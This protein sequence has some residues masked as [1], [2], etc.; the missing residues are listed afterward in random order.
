MEDII[1]ILSIQTNSD[2]KFID[3]VRIS[4]PNSDN[5]QAPI[6]LFDDAKRKQFLDKINQNNDTMVTRKEFC[7]GISD[8]VKTTN[9]EKTTLKEK[10]EQLPKPIQNN[11]VTNDVFIPY[12]ENKL[13]MNNRIL[14]PQ[15]IKNL[16]QHYEKELIDEEISCTNQGNSSVEFK[17]LT[18][19]KV[20]LD[21]LNL[22]TPY[23][24]L[25]LYHGLG[26]GKTCSAIAIAEGM[27]SNKKIIV[28]TPASLR[29][30][31]LSELQK[32]ADP[33]YKKLQHWTFKL[34]KSLDEDQIKKL[35]TDTSFSYEYIKKQKKGIWVGD[36]LRESNFKELQKTQQNEIET[37]LKMI[38]E[39]KYTFLS[40]NG[41]INNKKMNEITKK[42]TINPFDD[43]VVIIDEAHNFISRI[44]NKLPKTEFIPKTNV[45][46]SE[47]KKIDPINSFN[48]TIS[49]KLYNYL[50]SASNVRIVLLT[51][52]P[53]INF[54]CE[55]AVLYNILRGHIYTW[56]LDID[57]DLVVNL[58]S[59]L[60]IFK[61]AKFNDYDYITYTNNKITVTRNPYGFINQRQNQN[62]QNVNN[63]ITIKKKINN[64]NKNKTVKQPPQKIINPVNPEYIPFP[65]QQIGGNSFDQYNGVSYK[66]HKTTDFKN[67]ETSN[68]EFISN[69]T[70]ILKRNKIYVKNETTATYNCLPHCPETF[71]KKFIDNKN[72]MQ[73]TQLYQKRV[74]GLTSYFRSA[75]ENLLPELV[76]SN[77]DNIFHVVKCEMSSHQIGIYAGIRAD[78]EEKEKNKKKIK[79]KAKTNIDGV[80]KIPSTYRIYSRACCNFAFPTELPRPMP[81]PF[82]T[83]DFDNKF[84]N[85]AFLDDEIN[86]DKEIGDEED[87]DDEDKDEKKRRNLIFLERKQKYVTDKNKTMTL[88]NDPKY[89]SK[90]KLS[91]FSPKFLAILENIQNELN[92]GLHLLYSTF[93]TI[94]GIAILVLVLEMNGYARFNIKS[95]IDGEIV[96]DEKDEDRNKP[97]F[98]LYTGTETPQEKEIMLNIFNGNWDLLPKIL[99]NQ[100]KNKDSE[101][102]NKFG[103]VIKL[104][105]ITA[106]GAEGITLKNTRFIHIV[107]P[108]WHMVRLTQVIGRARRICSHEALPKELQ[109]VK[110]FLYIS[111]FSEEQRIKGYIDLMLQDKSKDDDEIS[112]STDESLYESAKR[113]DVIIQ[114]FLN[115]IK[116]SAIDCTLFNKGAEKYECYKIPET[117]GISND[118]LTEPNYEDDEIDRVMINN[119]DYNNPSFQMY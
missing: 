37:Q 94:E 91:S 7:P 80:E 2:I 54:P 60:E 105:M 71:N 38:I 34:T 104:F 98:A 47:K 23:R 117:R 16:L 5:E 43:S 115:V 86:D 79:Q 14:F 51:G 111:T 88:L 100:L 6:D 107:E 66:D 50:M 52:T 4:F 45:K 35:S 49:G 68:K 83:E 87:A 30:N 58:K 73:N 72:A 113:K 78:E 103:K 112:I 12:T 24:G 63:K 65:R 119:I 33:L 29:P 84:D 85:E 116:T 18:H 118:F 99:S 28:M 1:N 92:K 102:K 3:G 90:E 57:S 93:R 40:F 69:I 17:K 106:S 110:V 22:S 96:I 13:Y 53:I 9:K 32:C 39:S 81:V 75:Q 25:L 82:D 31:F 109:T 95:N 15:K 26:S 27:K 41:G 55:S 108:F 20:V 46:K 89:L 8:L 114:Q 10:K 77:N 101:E 21:Y 62:P 59:I 70:E 11:V 74:I 67:Y 61:D 97:K 76:K 44:V 56:T 36:N 19:Q 64:T 48:K 42:N